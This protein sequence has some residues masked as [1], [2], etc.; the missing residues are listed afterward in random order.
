MRG[1]LYTL[2]DIHYIFKQ[3]RFL[4]LLISVCAMIS[5]TIVEESLFQNRTTFHLLFGTF[6]ADEN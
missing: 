1:L 3:Y 2:M 4:E 6:R 5:V